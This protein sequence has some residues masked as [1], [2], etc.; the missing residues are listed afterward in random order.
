VVLKRREG[1]G[2]GKEKGREGGAA[3]AEYPG[4][5]KCGTFNWSF[6]GSKSGVAAELWEGYIICLCKGT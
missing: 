6:S 3:G 1:D 4:G 5:I 2:V